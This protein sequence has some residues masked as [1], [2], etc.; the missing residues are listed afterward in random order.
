MVESGRRLLVHAGRHKTGSSAIQQSL[1]SLVD[2]LNFEYIDVGT[3]NLSLVINRCFRPRWVQ[4]NNPGTGKHVANIMASAKEQLR[5]AVEA[6]YKAN[7]ILSAEDVSMLD[8]DEFENFLQFFRLYFKKIELLAY[9][10]A[11]KPDMESAFFEKLKHNLVS[12]EDSVV[13]MHKRRFKMFEKHLGRS[14]MAYYRYAYSDFPNGDVVGHFWSAI[15]LG[16]S[17]SVKLTVNRRLSLSGMRLLYMYRLQFPQSDARDAALLEKLLE[18]GGP[19]F[20]FHSQLFKKNFSDPINSFRWLEE[21]TQKSFHEEIDTY[22]GYSILG[23]SG[24]MQVDEYARKW[25]SRK[26]DAVLLQNATGQEQSRVV[27]LGLRD[28]AARLAKVG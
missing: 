15:G 3:P 6:T 27:A 25:L 19:A 4:L 21:R 9:F 11:P 16:D 1:L 13:F 17:P 2:H 20:H 22:D 26:V 28:Y 23:D 24:L 14:N 5:R 8:E 12:S 7:V 10:R 18:I